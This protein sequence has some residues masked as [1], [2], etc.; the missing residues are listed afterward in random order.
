[1]RGED[2]FSHTVHASIDFVS[3]LTARL[4]KSQPRPAQPDFKFRGFNS[5]NMP[6][7]LRKLME[8]RQ[9]ESIDSISGNN[10]VRR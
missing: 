8:K 6:W 10:R 5:E 1:V 2:Y 3:S 7:M 4:A 9:H